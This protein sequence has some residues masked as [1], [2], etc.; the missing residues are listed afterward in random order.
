MMSGGRRKLDLRSVE[1]RP[2][3]RASGP[4]RQRAGGQEGHWRPAGV[5]DSR[6]KSPPHPECRIP[7]EEFAP[8]RTKQTSKSGAKGQSSGVPVPLTWRSGSTLGCTA[9]EE[10]QGCRKKGPV[11]VSVSPFLKGR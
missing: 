4:Q 2:P 6:M 10:A 1:S 11:G 8:G 3:G 7:D 5:P 9:K